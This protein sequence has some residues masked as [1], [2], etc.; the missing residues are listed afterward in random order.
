MVRLHLTL[1]GGFHATIEPGRVLVLPIKKTQALLAYLALPLGRAH[2]REKLAALLWGDMPD[3][4]ARG[5]LRHALSRIRTALPRA[6]RPG[7][8]LDGP[9]VA[10]DPSAVDVDVARFE[11][12][13]ADGRPDALERAPGI[14][15][16]DLLAGLALAERPFE[17]WL[18]SERERLHELHIQGL[19]RLL[20]H[21]QRSDAAEP[22]VHTGLR[23]LAL[24]PAQEPV[25]RALM[26]LYTRL[27]R[28]EAALRQ[29]QL[30]V[31]A[32][33]RELGASPDA[34]T[35]RL[36]QEILRGRPIH[37][38]RDEAP[39]RP[40]T[41]PPTNLPAPAS[42]L[43]GRAAAVTEVKELLGAH[44]LVTLSG[45][46]GIGKTRLGLQVARELW[47]AFAD[48]AWVAELAPLSDPGLV[49]VTV[50]VALGLTL[51]AGPGSPE[52]VA[53]AIGTKRLL[54]VLDNCEH[55]IEAA[56]RMA[57]AVMRASSEARVLV[58][59]REPLRAPGEHVYRV[60]PL[61]VPA[62]D[63][64][65]P[66]DPLEAAAVRLFVARARAMDRRF[67][68]GAR[69]AALAGAICRR[70]DGMPLAIELAAARAATLGVEAL[71]AG[72]DDR[73]RLLTGGHRAVLPRHQTL[74]AT[75][76]WSYALLPAMERTV[77]HRLAIFAGPFTLEASGAVA[78]LDDLDEPEVVDAVNNLA[79]KSLVSVDLDE[80][81]TRYRLLETTRAYALEKLV[82]SGELH[83]VARRHAEY[84]RDLFERAEAERQTRPTRARPA[85]YARQLDGAR[86]ALDWAFSPGGDA[87]LGIALT[88]ATVPL[89]MH[90]SL[91][92]E[93]CDRVERAIAS[94]GPRVPP[95]PRRDMRVFL[96]L[97]T[98]LLHTR[99]LGS[100]EM[101]AALT[102][103]LEIAERLDDHEY[104]LRALYELYVQRL[105]VSD[106]RGALSLAERFVDVA[107]RAADPTD[108]LV[109][110]R[111]VGTVL[112]VL[113]DQPGAWRHVEPLARADV[114]AA[115]RSHI[116][117]Y[118]FDQRVVAW[119]FRARIRWLQGFPDQ[120]L[121]AAEDVVDYAREQDHLASL[122]YALFQAA[123]PIALYAGDL[124]RADRFVT[125]LT[126]ISV[127][128]TME[129]WSVWARCFE[130]VL[131]IRRG[132]S[133]AG[134]R[135]LRAALGGLPAVAFHMHHTP[136]LA[137]LAE[138]LGAGGQV[139]DGLAVIDDAL[140]R[141]ERAE[142]RW[143]WAELLRKKGELLRLG[144]AR[145]AAAEA[146]D[147]FARAL[148]WAR[149]H[150]TP[151]WELRAA[152]SLARLWHEQGRPGPARELLTPIHGRFTEGFDSADLR[153]ARTLLG[154]LDPA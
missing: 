86:S 22:A 141:A 121:R 131:V 88:V 87:A 10:L 146:E 78:T 12:L 59:S 83:R 21:Q 34:E 42:E 67:A 142:E 80:A 139:A 122:F 144:T 6:T 24:D 124:A 47:P 118:Q 40:A 36:Y 15:R 76:D 58:T 85:A 129:A 26:R 32:L 111:L 65:T 74:R 125:L 9:S 50:A 138:G 53:A 69:A 116:V 110:G 44:R 133:L 71:A 54:L 16:G 61:E 52:R 97:G 84:H 38:D 1:L 109:G 114:A 93:C 123:C 154:S 92:T 2:A 103:A 89:W 151:S 104:R 108:A 3:A 29:Y 102:K 66:G 27:G 81:I 107:A 41:S 43:I 137:E 113:G 82:E 94:L 73:F 14:Y 95:D 152:T 56:A 119:S 33:K 79:A 117:R 147:H 136:F 126:E 20:T 28:R 62:E 143:L 11:A 60:F 57:D 13:V 127:R 145:T 7:L 64:A 115:R 39:G 30:C 90:L 134:S 23:L 55:L 153:A 106:Y 140:A 99:R 128:Q 37:L 150:D 98:A 8:I 25:H 91:M 4:Q 105:V 35:A 19:G 96:A 112:H 101:T 120:A 63:A 130:G 68:P 100:P 72:L 149:R 148:D 49:P 48:G 135:L 70:L 31:E 132:E 45:A 77:L 51:P 5:N 46:G 18:A 75:L 17:E